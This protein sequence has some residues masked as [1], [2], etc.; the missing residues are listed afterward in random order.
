[1]LGEEEGGGRGEVAGGGCWAYRLVLVFEPDPLE[2]FELSDFEPSDVE[3]PDVDESDL[4]LSD[5]ELSD[6]EPESDELVELASDSFFSLSTRA[7]PLRPPL[8]RLSFL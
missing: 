8:E 5:L 6:L 7:P 2:L 4:E 1:V 3:E